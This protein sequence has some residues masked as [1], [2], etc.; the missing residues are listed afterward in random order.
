MAGLP[1]VAVSFG[2][3]DRP[4]TALG[5]AAVIDR[6]DDLPETLARLRGREPFL[7]VDGLRLARNRMFFSSAKAERELGYEAGSH[8][9]GLDAAL[10]WFAQAGYLSR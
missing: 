9:A 3:R 5:A 4:A 2:Y 6:F 1:L 10:A 7:T 8:I